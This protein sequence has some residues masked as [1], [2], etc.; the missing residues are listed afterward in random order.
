MGKPAIDVAKLSREEQ[1]EL[2]D[3][4]WR[5]LGHDPDPF[6]LTDAQ[7]QDLDERLDRLD[8]EGPDGFTWEEVVER[9][10]RPK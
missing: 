9:L 5:V 7:R 3:E 2:L 10:R 6:P 4:L 8:A 1:L